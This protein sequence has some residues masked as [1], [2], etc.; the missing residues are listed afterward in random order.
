MLNDNLFSVSGGGGG[1][2]RPSDAD[3]L[4]FDDIQSLSN[5]SGQSR[6]SVS[7]AVPDSTSENGPMAMDVEQERNDFPDSGIE[8]PGSVR[9]SG[10]F[11]GPSVA[12]GILIPGK[13]LISGIRDQRQ[14]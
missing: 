3:L 8:E 10:G 2:Y 6:A 11:G 13:C 4:L 14:R 5:R 1:P 7:I 12:Q 9:V